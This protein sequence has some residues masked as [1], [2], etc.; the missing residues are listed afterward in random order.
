LCAGG[1]GVLARVIGPRQPT[2]QHVLKAVQNPEIAVEGTM[3]EDRDDIL[4]LLSEYSARLPLYGTMDVM[5]R[6]WFTRLWVIQEMSLGPEVSFTCGSRAM[7]SECFRA[8]ILFYSIYINHWIATVGQ[9]MP[10]AESKLREHVLDLNNNVIRLFQERRD[11]HFRGSKPAYYDVVLKY[12]VN[13]R[14]PKICVSRPEDRLFGLLGIVAEDDTRG[15]VQVRYAN[16]ENPGDTTTAAVFTEFAAN[17]IQKN[18]DLLLFSQMETKRIAKLPTWVPDWSA[19][20]ATPHGYLELKKPAFKAGLATDLGIEYDPPHVCMSSKTLFTQGFRVDEVRYIGK[21]TLKQD[22]SSVV[23]S[24]DYVSVK[25]FFDEIQEFIEKAAQVESSPYKG[26]TGE[27]LLQIRIRLSVFGLTAKHL[28]ESRNPDN[29]DTRLKAMHQQEYAWAAKVTQIAALGDIHHFSNVLDLFHISARHWFPL[30]QFEFLCFCATNPIVML[31]A[32]IIGVSRIVSDIFRA[33]VVSI[34][35]TII[36]RLLLIRR[37]FA[38][39][40]SRAMGSANTALEHVGLDDDIAR[41]LEMKPYRDHM[42]R[43][44][45]LRLYVTKRGYIGLGPGHLKKDDVLVVI[46]GGTVPHFLR[47]A[48]ETSDGGTNITDPCDFS[49]VGEAYCFGIMDGQLLTCGFDPEMFHIR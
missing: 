47:S 18:V 13:D 26:L 25:Q 5:S 4:A 14:L 34:T 39:L 22:Q 6:P 1:D 32:C 42:L 40:Q 23:E 11:I 38:E 48:W 9:T 27:E 3:R 12:N 33:F 36:M 29:I 8:G 49:Y 37:R 16:P 15:T 20:L 28:S 41:A 7:C 17:L 46:L 30:P 21:C 19:D 45:G 43:A 44:I 35:L 31:L 24:I 2:F 10:M